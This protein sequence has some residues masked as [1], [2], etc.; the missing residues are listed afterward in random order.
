MPDRVHRLKPAASTLMEY[1]PG[2]RNG[3]RKSPLAFVGAVARTPVSALVACTIA[4]TTTAPAG[5]VTRPR[6][7]LRA[8]C[9]R[10]GVVS[11]ER[12]A[13]A[14]RARLWNRIADPLKAAV[15]GG[16]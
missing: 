15:L 7:V 6:I 16:G 5:S 11:K 4:P 2:I 3:N 9:A 12:A 10:R 14:S 8:S 13:A 1:G